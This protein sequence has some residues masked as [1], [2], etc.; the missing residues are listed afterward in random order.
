IEFVSGFFSFFSEFKTVIFYL[1]V[2]LAGLIRVVNVKQVLLAGVIGGCLVLFA[3]VWT[4]I[5]GQYRSFLNGGT[6]QQVTTVSQDAALNKLYD[7]SNNVDE[8]SLN[9][10]VY[11][12]LDRLQYTYHFAR[13]IGRVPS[14]IPF[15]KGK[16]WT[17]NI[18]FVTT[19]R[20]LNPNKPT[21]DATE[22]AKKYTGLRYAGR[23]SGASF[24]LGY[25][26]ECYIDFGSW[27]MMF[28]LFL[29][30]LMYGLAYWY[31]LRNS[32]NNY[33]FNY[34][35]VG[36]FFMEFNAFEMDGTL[37]IGRFLA[38]F[39]TF[40]FLIKVAFPMIITYISEP[41]PVKR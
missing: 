35:V 21:F 38:T 25:F 20:F 3:L 18:Q 23:R 28:P 32:S 6:R 29:I 39:V 36:A 9:S 24:S 14:V 22:K 17:D 30:G 41:Q 31:L 10:S 33:I 15:Q 16:N 26:A 27:G 7:L 19:P 5:K 40:V 11:Q 13:T 2:L 12:L 4:Q 34:A 1:I 37:L 8:E